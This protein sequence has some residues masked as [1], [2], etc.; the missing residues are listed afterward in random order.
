MSEP[1]K[2]CQYSTASKCFGVIISKLQW[3]TNILSFLSVN[4]LI[5]LEDCLFIVD[6]KWSECRRTALILNEVLFFD[7]CSSGIP[8]SGEYILLSYWLVE[9]QSWAVRFCWFMHLI[10]IQYPNH[11]S[12]SVTLIIYPNAL[13]ISTTPINNLECHSVNDSVFCHS[14]HGMTNF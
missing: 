9:F 6:D 8:C 12:E 4:P 11:L 5:A 10:L 1:H 14:L 13:P 2:P 7:Y 3:Q